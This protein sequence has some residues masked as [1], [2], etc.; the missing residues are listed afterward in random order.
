MP[1]KVCVVTGSNSGIGFETARGLSAEGAEVI[2][3]ARNKERGERARERIASE[4]GKRMVLVLCDLSLTTE[5]KRLAGE[6]VASYPRVHVLDNNAGAVF[7]RRTITSEGHEATFALD[8]LAPF[9]LTHLMLPS[10]RAAS[11]SRVISVT[12]GLQRRGRFHLDDLESTKGYTGIGAYANAKLMLTMFTYYMAHL[13]DGLGVTVNCLEPGFVATNLGMG[14]G[15]L[16]QSIA[17][18]VMRPFQNS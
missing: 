17:F 5:V 15:S 11:P 8:Y 12:S 10:L 4:T 18:S 3:V 7:L 6:L 16:A 1:G 13:L 9:A 2:M 14:S